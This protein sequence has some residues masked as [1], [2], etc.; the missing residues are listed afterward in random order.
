MA[1]GYYDT[2]GTTSAHWRLVIIVTDGTAY[3]TREARC[4]GETY[5]DYEPAPLFPELEPLRQAI[6]RL[7]SG[8]VHL[9]HGARPA[10]PHPPYLCP[11]I[12]A[13]LNTG[14][15]LRRMRASTGLAR[16]RA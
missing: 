10:T 8:I 1:P 4:Y 6:E 2:T 12:G 3:S 7:R 11:M 14:M 9:L 16:G 13:A 15:H 5:Y